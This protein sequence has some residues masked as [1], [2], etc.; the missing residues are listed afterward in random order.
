MYDLGARTNASDTPA[1]LPTCPNAESIMSSDAKK[2]KKRVSI[3]KWGRKRFVVNRD[4]WTMSVYFPPETTDDI[5]VPLTFDDL[6]VIP[7][8]INRPPNPAEA[9]R[10][11]TN[12]ISAKISTRLCQEHINSLKYFFRGLVSI[13]LF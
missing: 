5:N 8:C 4:S 1:S 7:H 11:L 10:L 2:F 6:P 9:P 12:A 3:T 13:D